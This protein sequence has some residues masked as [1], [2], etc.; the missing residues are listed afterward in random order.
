MALSK[1]TKI[2]ESKEL[3]LRFEVFNLFNHPKFQNPDG[4]IDDGLPQ[5]GGTFGLVTAARDPRIMQ[6]GAKFIF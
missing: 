3:Q 4:T 5:D 6:I 2:T 1:T